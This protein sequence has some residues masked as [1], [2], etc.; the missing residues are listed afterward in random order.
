MIDYSLTGDIARITLDSPQTAN[1]FTHAMMTDYISALADATARKALIL[2]ISGA[3]DDF[4]RGRDQREKVP[5]VSREENLGLILRANALLGGFPGVSISAIQGCCMGFGLGIALHSDIAIAADTAIVGFDEIHHGL[6]P[7]VV[8]AYLKHF[9]GPKAAA[10]LVLTGRDVAATEA[11]QIG[12]VSRVVAADRLGSAAEE[13][14]AGLAAS[15]PGALRLIQSFSKR[16]NPLPDAA[17]GRQ[18]VEELAAWI[19]AGKPG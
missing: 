8:V 12:L 3:G 6:A 13:L 11:R 9:V 19:A 10:E 16:V 1:R 4:T 17:L 5:H 2:F 7:L 15:H 18:G 14:I